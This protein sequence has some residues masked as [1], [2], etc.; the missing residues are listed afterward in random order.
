MRLRSILPPI[1]LLPLLAVPAQAQNCSD[2][3][4]RLTQGDYEQSFNG[5][6]TIV[7]R[8]NERGHIRTYLRSGRE[9]PHTL[10]VQ[11]GHPKRFG[12]RGQDPIKVRQVLRIDAQKP[13]NEKRGRVLFTSVDPG[14]TTLGYR[15]VGANKPEVFNKVP[16]A[17]RTGILNFRVE[18]QNRAQSTD[19][20]P[21]P[22][23]SQVAWLA[24]TYESDFGVLVLEQNGD[25]VVGTYAHKG[26]QVRGTI[27]G[28][29]LRGTWSQEPSYRGPND[30]G[31][32]EFTFNRGSFNGWWRYGN[33]GPWEGQWNGQP[34][35]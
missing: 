7:L 27:H 25:A 2:L 13:E 10:S 4:V 21:N 20:R 12:L 24:G 31:D 1:L 35:R 11:Y 28:N 22:G 26:G 6:E 15:I 34:R 17:C 9:H 3:V 29:M 18:G 16:R 5:G 19:T 32:F 8:P 23:Q 33:Q 14:T 30:S